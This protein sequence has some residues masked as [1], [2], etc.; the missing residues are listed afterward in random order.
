M[1]NT[2]L[3]TDQRR[4][5]ELRRSA[6]LDLDRGWKYLRRRQ[7]MCGTWRTPL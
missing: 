5:T 2:A 6:G 7:Q 1:I 4:R 3:R